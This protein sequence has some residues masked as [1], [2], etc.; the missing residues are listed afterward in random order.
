MK[1][2]AILRGLEA[3]TGPILEHLFTNRCRVRNRTANDLSSSVT[4]GPPTSKPPFS[5]LL[6]RKASLPYTARQ[7]Q[8]ERGAEGGGNRVKREGKRRLG[9]IISSSPACISANGTK[10][11]GYAPGKPALFGPGPGRA[12][13]EHST[14]DILTQ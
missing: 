10:S 4:C 3:G 5:I 7:Q 1:G 12:R 13:G 14:P 2:P 9:K 6:G 8:G 11:S